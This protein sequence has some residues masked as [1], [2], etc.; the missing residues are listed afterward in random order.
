MTKTHHR[1]VVV[2]AVA[3]VCIATLVLWYGRRPSEHPIVEAELRSF[4]RMELLETSEE[5]LYVGNATEVGDLA[6]FPIF[7]AKRE[8]DHDPMLSLQL[9]LAKKV[10]ELR[11]D[12]NAT[13]EKLLVENKSPL[14][15]YVIAGTIVKGGNQDR[16][17]GED[18][19]VPPRSKVSVGAFCVEHGRWSGTR[20]GATTEGQFEALDILAT[21]RVRAAG[22][23]EHDQSSVWSEVGKV[24]AKHGKHAPSGTL[25]ATVDDRDIAASRERLTQALNVELSRAQPQENLVGFA[26]AFHGKVRGVRWFANHQL[27]ASFREI[28]A[29]TAAADWLD[30]PK[31]PRAAPP[32]PSAVTSF[33]RDVDREKPE[34]KNTSGKNSN[35]IRKAK[36]GY[37]ASTRLK[38][39]GGKKHA[40]LSRDYV[41]K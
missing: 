34:E 26:Y 3:F 9:A 30:T 38:G 7:S 15:I 8:T 12:E 14:P 11:E 33:V 17:I 36:K 23:Y 39:P 1:V 22:Q 29:R 25:L 6:I 32:P 21:P 19:V 18:V 41:S 27:F 5:K 20:E 10:A 40:P 13:V 2:A 31:G 37:G 35:S 28:L 4:D 16:Q 24:N